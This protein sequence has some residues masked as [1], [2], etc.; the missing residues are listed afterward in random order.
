LSNI[1]GLSGRIVTRLD[2]KEDWSQLLKWVTTVS[3]NRW[4]VGL[5]PSQLR[6]P[7]HER[8]RRHAIFK[9]DIATLLADTLLSA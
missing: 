3:Q 1:A 2:L 8:P 7:V 6:L 5:C 4:I 9:K